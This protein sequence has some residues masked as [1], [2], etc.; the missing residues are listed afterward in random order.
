MTPILLPAESNPLWTRARTIVAALRARA[1]S[2]PFIVAA[3]VDGYAE[4][5]WTAIISGDHDE[6]FGP[7]QIQWKYGGHE[8]L[9]ELGIDIRTEPS[10]DRHVAALLWLIETPPYA[11]TLAALDVAN[12][13]VEATQIFAAGF[14]RAGAADAVARRVAAAP[15]M[16][17]WL[18]KEGA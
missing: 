4:S 18:A 12:T 14:E 17:V 5:A 10:L 8:I 15:E 3:L 16:D 7:W 2:N 6:S 11:A 9:S 1:K 13:A